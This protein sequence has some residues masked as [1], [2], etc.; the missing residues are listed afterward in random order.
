MQNVVIHGV[1][2]PEDAIG[3]LNSEAFGDDVDA[4]LWRA[5]ARSE[6]KLTPSVA[7]KAAPAPKSVALASTPAKPVK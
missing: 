3:I 5:I 6:G 1:A 7:T 2:R 4:V